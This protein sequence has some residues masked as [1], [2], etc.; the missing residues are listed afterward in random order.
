MNWFLIVEDNG[1]K[2]RNYR[3]FEAYYRNHKPPFHFE[4]VD[5]P[6]DA[7]DMLND[8]ERPEGLLGVIADF[9]LGAWREDQ[10]SYRA[11]VSAEVDPDHH[12]YQIYTGMGILDWAHTTA[13]DIPLWALTDV[14]AGHAPLFMSAAN[15]WL[16]AKPLAIGRFTQRGPLSDQLLQELMQPHRFAELNP[17]WP[18]VENATAAFEYLLNKTYSNIESFDW[19]SAL[20][21]MPLWPINSKG[22]ESAYKKEVA[23]ISGSERVKFYT[24]T[25]ARDMTAWQWCLDDMYRQ[26]PVNRQAELWPVFTEEQKGLRAW[27]DFNPFTDFLGRN[28]ECKEFFAA[29]DVRVAMQRWRRNQPDS[30]TEP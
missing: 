7:F 22:F 4:I 13:P 10:A 14:T 25:F 6:V 9:S 15:L 26:F 17:I 16:D 12:G 29:P 3:L 8:E 2:A 23:R 24:Q 30:D 19:I 28:N 5:T 1:K 21:N 27:S 11:S 20:V 18:K